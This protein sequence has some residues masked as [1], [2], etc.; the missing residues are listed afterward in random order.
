MLFPNEH[1]TTL[2]L[3]ENQ[4]KSN[5]LK[6][7][8]ILEYLKWLNYCLNAALIVCS[9]LNG[10]DAGVMLPMLFGI[11]SYLPNLLGNMKTTPTT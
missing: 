10:T 2:P 5:I 4:T 11:T 6:L 7:F 8:H 9:T 3:S 1:Y